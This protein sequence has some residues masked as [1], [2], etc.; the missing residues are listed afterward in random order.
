MAERRFHRKNPRASVRKGSA[1]P[2]KA[3]VF[4]LATAVGAVAALANAAVN[5]LHTRAPQLALAIDADDPVALVRSAQ[6]LRPAGANGSTTTLDVVQRSIARLPLNGP[7]FRLYALNGDSIADPELARAQMRLSDRM[8]RR[9]IGAQLWLIESAVEANDVTRALQHYDRALRIEESAR[10]LLYPVLTQAIDSP[11]IR[12]RFRPYMAA[13]P[14]W[15]ESFLR[16]AVSTTQRPVSLAGLARENDG[17]PEGAAFSSLDTELLAR[18]VDK[19]DFA[20]AAD[21]FRRIP[22]ADRSA[23]TSLRLT[24]ASTNWRHA[25]IT[26]QPYRIDGIQPHIL[27]SA[28]GAGAV[29]IEADLEAGYKG[30][31]ARKFL[32]LEPGTYELSARMRAENHSRQD[33]AIWAVTCAGADGARPLMRQEVALQETADLEGRIVVPADCPVQAVKV[34]AD[35]LV[36]TRFVKLVLASAELTPLAEAP[37]PVQAP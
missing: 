8:E 3:F 9:D 16:F 7:A 21:H 5:T 29:E 30:P 20:P 14:P 6:L 35:T 25:P 33:I 4:G 32:A 27:E 10:A 18:L 37:G 22:G 23:L 1:P 26:W 12:E 17:W 24:D 13:N 28:Q 31:V 36:T 15:L 34:S 19:G 2:L 11:L